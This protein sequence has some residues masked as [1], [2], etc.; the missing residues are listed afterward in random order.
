LESWEASGV[1]TRMN[2]A[3]SREP[4][5]KK[6]YVQDA[7]RDQS[8]WLK[9]QLTNGANLYICGS[10][11]MGHDVQSLLKELLGEDGFNAMEKEKR[12]IKELW[13]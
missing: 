1:L 8:E 12:L 7:M 2:L 13:G 3:L 10:T 11:K 6:T 9:D 5:I 4:G